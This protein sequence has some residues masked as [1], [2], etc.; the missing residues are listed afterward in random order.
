MHTISVIT[1]KSSAI[2]FIIGKHELQTFS[3]DAFEN[4]NEFMM[5]LKQITKI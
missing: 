4:F 3:N 2:Y 1:L 5:L